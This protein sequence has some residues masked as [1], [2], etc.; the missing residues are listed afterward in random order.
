MAEEYKQFQVTCRPYYSLN[1]CLLH[2]ICCLFCVHTGLLPSVTFGAMHG[3]WTGGNITAIGDPWW[4][5]KVWTSFA[6]TRTMILF[7]LVLRLVSYYV[8]APTRALAYRGYRLVGHHP[9]ARMDYGVTNNWAQYPSMSSRTCWVAIHDL[10][11]TRISKLHFV[12]TPCFHL[13]EKLE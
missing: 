12:L 4:A 2:A 10:K 3:R 6:P 1:V 9:P 7:P 11:F 8:E 5:Q 13:S